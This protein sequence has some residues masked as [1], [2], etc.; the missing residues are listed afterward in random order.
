MS[1]NVPVLAAATVLLVL[2]MALLLRRSN[3]RSGTRGQA[4]M[5]YAWLCLA[6]AAT[7][8]LF[9]FF[10]QTE[11]QGSAFGFSLGGA[12]AFV[13]VVLRAIMWVHG[14]VTEIDRGNAS[15]P[16]ARIPRQRTAATRTDQAPETLREF[17]VHPFL[18]DGVRGKRICLIT[19]NLRD[20]KCVDIWVNSENTEM[21]MSSQFER[22]ISGTIRYEGARR[23]EFG[24]IVED[25]IADELSAKVAGKTPVAPGVAIVT[26]SGELARSHNVAFVVHVAT[27]RGEPGEGFQQIGGID[28]CVTNALAAA[29]RLGADKPPR[30]IVFPPLGVG[31]GR[32]DRETTA[33]RMV[34]AAV[35][36][37]RQNPK[38]PLT[39]I[40]FLARKNLTRDAFLSALEETAGL[41]STGTH[42]RL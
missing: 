12:G 7:L 6:L 29:A 22:S 16:P 1:V 3:E 11:V 8:V 25:V 14:R 39:D 2:S 15:P 42:Q 13:F 19:G 35:G 27:V 37:L 30:S 32:G 24:H 21:Q 33:Q 31:S 4:T 36:Y 28:R 26:G 34:A 10:P 17:V 41:T 23:D 5:T 40:C 20:L 18:L 38:S 9:A